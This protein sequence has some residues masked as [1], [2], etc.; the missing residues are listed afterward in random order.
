MTT[1]HFW[2]TF[3][4]SA[5]GLILLLLLAACAGVGSNGTIN[6]IT[7]TIAGVDAAHHA[8]TLNVNG[9]T[10]TISGLSDQEI[11]SLQSQIGKPYTLHVKQNSDGSFSLTIGTSP[12]LAINETPGV[13]EGPEP[14]ETPEGSETPSATGK[15]DSISFTGSLQSSSSSSLTASLPDGSSLTIAINAQTDLSGLNSAQLHSGQSVKIDAL[16]SANG[17][18]AEKIKLADAG[19]QNDAHTVDFQGHASQ[20]VGSD[21]VLHFTVGNRTFSYALGRTADLSD[22]G[23]NVSAITSGAALKVKVVFNGTT[24]SVIN[25]SKA[26]G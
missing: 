14:G 18:V 4:L 25:V 1:T 16:A 8:I 13:N 5:L 21:R 10:Y 20:T 19:E 22:F 17:F 26:D 2:R 9:Q 3:R 12:A 23:G 24:G 15:A 6:S 7:G 11:Q